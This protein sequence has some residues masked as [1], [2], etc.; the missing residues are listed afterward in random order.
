MTPTRPSPCV[1]SGRPA[2]LKTSVST[3][4][5]LAGSVTVHT[6]APTARRHSVRLDDT[7][8]LTAGRR[9]TPPR[10][11]PPAKGGQ[12]FPHPVPQSLVEEDQPLPFTGSEDLN[13]FYNIKPVQ[14][15][16][17][18]S[19][20]TKSYFCLPDCKIFIDKC[21]PDPAPCFLERAVTHS[22]FDPDYF[23]SLHKLVSAPGQDYPA[24]TYNFLGAKIPL[25]HT[26]L[27]IPKWRELFSSYPKADI[28]D[29]LEFGF[30]IGVCSDPNLEPALK[31]H[32]SSYLYYSWVDKFCVKEISKCG[33]T[34]PLGTIPF[35]D[36]HI[37]P[38]MTAVKKPSKRRVVFDASYGISLNKSTPKE[39]YLHEKA[40]YDFPK[41]DDF[42]LLILKVGLGARM[43]K[44][45]LERYFLQLPIDPVD[46]SRTG[47]VWRSNF[48]FFVS[49][50]F[51][52]RHSGLAGQSV[53]SAV[54]WRHRQ[55]GARLD[56][57]EFN[58]LNY[59]DDLAGVEAG[60]RSD[61]SY[62]K[63]GQLLEELGLKEAADK[64]TP[65]DTTITYL[66]VTFDSIT[67]KKTVPAEKLAELLDILNTWSSKK[68]CTKRGLQSLV[69]KLLWV[70]RCVRFSRVFVSRLLAALKALATALPHHKIALSQEM[71][72]D[73]K[74]WLTYI[75]SFNG[76]M[77]IINPGIIKFSYKGDACLDGG[78]G[79]H[80]QEY[81]SRPLPL[82]M[83]GKETPIHLKEYWVLLISIKLWGHLW[84]GSTVELFVDN[85]AVCLTC[86]NQKPTDPLMA[87]FLRE[88]L[89]L[90]VYYKFNPIVKHIGTKANFIADYLSR[91]FNP[92]EAASFFESH[93]MGGMRLLT[94]PD[95]MFTFTSDW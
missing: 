48:F 12:A 62:Q 91:K 69:G 87:A 83:Q 38:M 53:T 30:P 26:Q 64:A 37:S 78:G 58:T 44:R 32:S 68:S 4:W 77:F 23:L 65:P 46:Y 95:S 52:L 22:R 60:T 82:W 49:Y 24:N 20:L 40:E 39:F 9:R 93:N 76:V 28:I 88:F 2:A 25:V 80:D 3:R 15:E 90:V 42:E 36:Y 5:I 54:T 92:S 45:D 17:K 31:N 21:L 73:I 56:G 35:S 6:T 86:T 16:I 74:W 51:G 89:F 18:V 43:W 84:S 13:L 34:G 29:K 47:F 19:T 59:S 85:T 7:R 55:E 70:A 50:M 81:W 79:F 14:P 27:N 8:S 75:R 71:Q 61:L 67:M 63:M 72:L 11:S 57:E 1:P 66:G 94:V 10:T 33:M 41:L